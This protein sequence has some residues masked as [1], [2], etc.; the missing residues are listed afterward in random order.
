MKSPFRV[1]SFFANQT[2][3][4]PGRRT[5][6][7]PLPAQEKDPRSLAHEQV[8][9]QFETVHASTGS[10]DWLT[11]GDSFNGDQAVVKNG[12]LKP[13]A[14]VIGGILVVA[15]FWAISTLIAIKTFGIGAVLIW[16][17]SFFP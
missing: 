14:Y 4:T 7:E 13:L 8:G 12:G 2:S 15:S 10:R 3:E 1:E 5:E 17:G 11:D 9:G 16:A 6:R